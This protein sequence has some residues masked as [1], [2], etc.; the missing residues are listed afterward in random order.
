MTPWDMNLNC[1]VDY[2]SFDNHINYSSNCYTIPDL[3]DFATEAINDYLSLGSANSVSLSITY[4]NYD[5]VTYDWWGNTISACQNIDNYYWDN[6]GF[7]C[8]D[9]V[10]VSFYIN[11]ETIDPCLVYNSADYGNWCNQWDITFNGLFPYIDQWT[12]INDLLGVDED[13]WLQS[14]NCD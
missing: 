6:D 4:W 7:E 3:Y 8:E 13:S 9:N 12:F 14:Q 10:R 1:Y 5:Y 11:I 2:S